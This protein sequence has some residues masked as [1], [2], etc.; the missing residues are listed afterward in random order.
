MPVGPEVIERVYR[1]QF[2]RF[3]RAMVAVT[4]NPD[5]AR[6]AVQEGFARALV[7]CQTYRGE[8]S[9]EGWIWR[10]ALNA[11]ADARRHARE[12]PLEEAFALQLPSPQTDPILSDALRQLPP[13]QRLLIFLH[14]LADLSYE[15]IARVCGISE[16]TVGAS[17]SKARHTLASL[18]EDERPEG[19]A[20]PAGRSRHG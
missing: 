10:I 7:A 9:L 12:Q 14:Y 16:G 11:A 1:E 8:G 19:H 15:D 6:D 3:F 5:D 13:R 20:P 18:L 4:G 17:L 2:T